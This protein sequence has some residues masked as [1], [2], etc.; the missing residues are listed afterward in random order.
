M[1]GTSISNIG[2]SLIARSARRLLLAALLPGAV[3]VVPCHAQQ[4]PVVELQQD[5][6]LGDATGATFGEVLR[7]GVN[8]RGTIYVGDGSNASVFIFSASGT[9]LDTIGRRGRGPGEFTAVHDLT[10]GRGDSLYVFDANAMRLSVFGGADVAHKL[11]YS[12][13]PETG[14][15]GRP[16]RILIPN[17][18]R[19]APLF[20]FRDAAASTISVHRVLAGGTVDARPVLQGVAADSRVNYRQSDGGAELIRTSPLFGRGPVVGITGRDEVFYGWTEKVD[21]TFFDLTGKQQ[22]IFR[23]ESRAVPVA[24]R[25]IEHALRGSSEARRRALAQAEHTKTKPALHTVLIDDEARIWTGHYTSD[26]DRHEWWVRF[27]YGRGETA[28]LSLPSVVEL[29]VVRKGYA[30]AASVDGDGAP[31][32]IRYRITVHPRR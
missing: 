7:L 8:S 11:V 15:F 27:D 22:S 9:A 4:R 5:L 14:E 31:T 28:I 25:D 10:V 21:L 2:G 6:V 24:S 13:M 29:Q 17:E 20:V 12:V 3:A 26:P 1:L 19:A 30:Y 32:V 18:A 23:A 16:F